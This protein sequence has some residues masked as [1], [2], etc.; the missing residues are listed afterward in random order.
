MND[1]DTALPDP[2]VLNA[3]Y[4]KR[5]PRLGSSVLCSSVYALNRYFVAKVGDRTTPGEAA[6][7][8]F[9]RHRGVP[10]PEVYLHFADPTTGEYCIIM[11]RIDG[12]PLE[13]APGLDDP[14]WR[15][16]ITSQLAAIL[17]ALRDL[18]LDESSEKIIGSLCFVRPEAAASEGIALGPVRDAFF[19][20]RKGGQAPG[21][22][23]TELGFREAIMECVDRRGDRSDGTDLALSL[24]EQMPGTESGQNEEQEIVFTHGQLDA[25]HILVK[26]DK[27]VGIVDWSQAGFYPGYWEYVKAHFW[28][29]DNEQA[30]AIIREAMEPRQMELA[31]WLHAKSVIW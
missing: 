25:R 1:T 5:H 2:E 15:G 4:L 19:S 27:V 26:G 7:M 21:L 12:T 14:S 30:N 28:P 8:I 13:E 23:R 24:L 18:K 10:V 16:T 29:S 31:V 11:E 20:D 17:K 9:L 22:Y 3:A 6:T